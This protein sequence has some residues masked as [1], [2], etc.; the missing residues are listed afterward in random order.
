M[1]YLDDDLPLGTRTCNLVT[2]PDYDGFG[3]SMRSNDKGPHQIS[4]VE[5]DSP[6]MIAG[7]R[8]DDLILR[9]NESSVLG[10]RYSKTVT[11]I[12]NESQSGRLKLDV[13][14][15]EECPLAIRNIPLAK[16]HTPTQTGTLTSQAS[17]ASNG[18]SGSKKISK[19]GSIENLKEITKEAM[20]QPQ[21]RPVSA[22]PTSLNQQ[23]RPLSMNDIDRVSLSNAAGSIIPTPSGP[24]VPGGTVKSTSAS[25][26][27]AKSM[28]NLSTSKQQEPKPKFKR[29]LVILPPLPAASEEDSSSAPVKGYGF[30]L[31]SKVKPKYMI[32]SVDPQSVSYA[33]NLRATD[34]I[35]EI[36][37][38]NIR[39]LKFDQVK[40]MIIDSQKNRRQVEILAISKEG[41]M[42]YKERRKRFSSRKLVTTENTEPY[43]SLIGISSVNVATCKLL[44]F[45]INHGLLSVKTI[46]DRSQMG[47]KNDC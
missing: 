39:R 37:K 42:Y 32:F 1:Y 34:V 12:K 35:V 27:S 22:D 2:R 15:V 36:D 13:I 24:T 47:E 19:K 3:F 45:K 44:V 9:V 17:L 11:L 7:L 40:Q 21:Q 38:K 46:S 29:C 5:I 20:H 8:A 6:A 28:G 4:Q 23:R 25:M 26:Q 18:S 10:E 43:S 30:T 16:P 31:N 14:S 41:Y 33:A